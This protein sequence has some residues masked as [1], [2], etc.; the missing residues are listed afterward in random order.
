M[1]S[2]HEIAG[3]QCDVAE[4]PRLG[5]LRAQN[6]RVVQSARELRRAKEVQLMLEAGLARDQGVIDTLKGDYGFIRYV[7][8]CVIH[9]SV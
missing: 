1:I 2:Q 9:C 3:A 6:I 7:S 8:K 5:Y 4:I